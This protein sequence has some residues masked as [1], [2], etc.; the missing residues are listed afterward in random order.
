MFEPGH[1][2]SHLSH[3]PS[4]RAPGYPARKSLNGLVFRFLII[5]TSS[6]NPNL[7]AIKNTY[8]NNKQDL[9][10]TLNLFSTMFKSFNTPSI[11]KRGTDDSVSSVGSVGNPRLKQEGWR[12]F[13]PFEAEHKG[14]LH[15]PKLGAKTTTKKEDWHHFTPFFTKP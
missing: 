15:L 3:P 14:H 10:N 9:S 5:P 7:S 8:T 6:H 12:D 13:I 2:A 11:Q 1:H 4:G